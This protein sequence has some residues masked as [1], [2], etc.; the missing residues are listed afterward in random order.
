[1]E[2][3]I[4][5]LLKTNGPLTGSEIKGFIPGDN[6]LLWQTCKTSSNLRVKSVGGRFLRLDRR[7]NGFA[8]LSP[9]ILREFLTYS[10]VGLA[11]QPQLIDQR[12]REIHSR[13]VQ[14]SRSK[15]ELARSF[16]DEV[17]AE[18]RETWLQ[19]QA[20][21]ILAGDIVYDMA[22]DVPRPERSTGRLVRGSDIDLVVIVNDS[23]RD[24]IIQRLDTAIYQKKYRA[25]ISPAVNEEI[26][27][28]VKKM[29]RVREQV[30]FDT[31]KN[32][33]ACKILQEGMLIGGSEGFY[34]EVIQLLPDN[35][36]L[37][38]LDRL[39]EAAI[40]LRKQQEDFLV[41]RDAD[42]ITPEDLY[43]FYPAEESEEFE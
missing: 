42:K 3:E 16:V 27:Y 21:F 28:V 22:H 40:A 34:R 8:R 30:R 11:G 12:A 32:M 39:R 43:F 2:Q 41:Q 38:K 14:V 6:L 35:G 26:D 7:V 31:F 13:I 5:N 36:V 23:V 10:V 4:I 15:L 1:M 19:E 37:E 18:L 29:E 24:P 9:S 20:C 17:K 25:L 33:V